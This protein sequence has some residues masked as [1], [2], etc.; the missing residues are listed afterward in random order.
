MLR[1][2]RDVRLAGA[3]TRSGPRLRVARTMYL[4]RT[5]ASSDLSHRERRS[6]EPDVAMI[7]QHENVVA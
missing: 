7:A 3:A 1:D 2:H 6:G 5:S 4:A